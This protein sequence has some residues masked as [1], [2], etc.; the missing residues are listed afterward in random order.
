MILFIANLFGNQSPSTLGSAGGS[1]PFSGSGFSGGG[2]NVA[3]TGFGVAKSQSPSGKLYTL[4][5]R[6]L[7]Y[8]SHI[9]DTEKL[10]L[11]V[12]HYC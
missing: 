6:Y 4:V 12:T 9:S 2:S 5:A 1:S 11:I 7:H 8:N 3:S 10:F